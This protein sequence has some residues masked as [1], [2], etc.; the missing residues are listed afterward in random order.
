MAY[1]D[2]KCRKCGNEF[3]IKASV[4]EREK[5]L[6]KCPGC[7]SNE[8]DRVYSKM[9]ISQ[10]TTPAKSETPSCPNIGRCG[11]CPMR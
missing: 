8:L 3:N 7:G 11:S 5:N 6:I 1:Y 10:R 9:N 4:E 2:L